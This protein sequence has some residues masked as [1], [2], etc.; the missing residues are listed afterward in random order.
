MASARGPLQPTTRRAV[1]AG[2]VAAL[3]PGAPGIAPPYA[4]VAQAASAPR[5]A[6]ISSWAYQLQGALIPALAASPYD[7]LVVD[8]TKNGDASL[9]LSR[10]EVQRLRTRPDGQPRI[11]L[12]YISIGEAEEY[13][14]YWRDEWLEVATPD[15]PAKPDTKVKSKASQGKP[16]ATTSAGAGPKAGAASLPA[17]GAKAT[18]KPDRWVSPDKAPKWLED[19]NES[20]GGNFGVKYWDAE[21]Q[22]L[23]FGSPDAYLERV[24]A[25]GFDGVYLDRVDAYYNHT[26]ERP[27]AADD[28]I[29]F[30]VRLAGA[31]RRLKPDC[32]IV[33]Q[34]A[35]ELLR[36]PAYLGII[37]GIAKE[38]LLFGSPHEGLANTPGQ[39]RNSLKWLETAR[40][41]GLTVLVIEYLDR[42]DVRAQARATITAAG[43]VPYF[44]P[45]S[46]DRLLLPDTEEQIRAAQ[47]AAAAGAAS[48]AP[49]TPGDG[50]GRSKAPATSGQPPGATSNRR[51][52]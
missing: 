48:T 51:R 21:W 38:D 6:R 45:R 23:I 12:S 46:L 40:A 13:R 19:E 7:V 2:G 32:I 49:A 20:W 37:D 24:L 5:L 41:H 10:A 39:V 30:V 3:A 15:E 29:D 25:Q 52:G 1:L 28:M 50:A 4:A 43:F 14:F 42:A 44:G 26:D 17:N 33:P 18:E 8:S 47:A 35:E 27:T 9:P 36:S 31:A 22:K 16:P 34:N 11:V